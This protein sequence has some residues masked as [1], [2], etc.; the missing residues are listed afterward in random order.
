MKKQSVKI[1]KRDDEVSKAPQ[2]R[3]EKPKKKR[4]IESTIQDWITERRED[5]DSR[6]RSLKTQFAAWN[7]KAAPAETA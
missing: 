7:T 3:K 1:I 6:N 2:T 5:T 4:S